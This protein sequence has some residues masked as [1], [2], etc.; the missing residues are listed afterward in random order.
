MEIAEMSS[1]KRKLF[2]GNLSW[3]ASEDDLRPLFEQYGEV[4]E[5]KVV[6]DNYTGKSRGFA[7]VVMANSED[8]QKAIDNLD[9]TDFLGRELRVSVAEDRRNSNP[10]EPR[11]GGFNRRE[12]NGGNY[13][14]NGYSRE[15][16]YN[17][18]GERSFAGGSRQRNG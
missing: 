15:G 10:R 9:K 6:L 3:K 18:G 17:R 11:E 16:G 4:T 14:D 8:A 12:N 2:I 13:R 1:D 7:F 5:V